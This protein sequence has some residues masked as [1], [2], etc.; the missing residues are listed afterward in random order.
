MPTWQQLRDVKLSEF[1]DAAD[2]WGKVSSRANAAKDRVDNEMRARIHETQKSKTAEGAV[3]DLGRLS[4]NYQYLHTE[5]GL[6]RTALDGLATELAEPQRKLKQALEDAENLKFT[7]ESD[8]AVKY[9]TTVAVTVP[10]APGP[11]V[12]R[13]GAPVPFLAGKGEGGGDPNKAKAEDIAERIAGA[14]RDAAEIDGRY[15]GVLRRLKSPAG[16]DVTN[17]MLVDAAADTKDV[18]KNAKFLPESNIPKGKSPADNK[19]WWDGLS[20]EERDEYATLY[21]AA[22][23]ALDG[24]PATVRDDA[25]R[26]VLAETRAQVQLDRDA[27]GPEPDRMIMTRRGGEPV[28]IENPEWRKWD[29]KRGP[30]DAKLKGMDAIQARFD[31]TG[32]ADRTGEHPLPEAYL[33]GFNADGIG[34]AIVANGNPDTATHTSVYVP[35]TG[36]NLEGINGDI[37]RMETLW[38]ASSAM[39]DGSK[40]STVTWF[41]YDA[42]QSIITDA[43]QSGYANEGGPV[44]NNFLG[45]LRASHE[46]EPGHLTAV[47]HSYGSTVI[48]SAAR[49]G[50]LP[51]DDVFVAG[52]PGEQVGHAS[53]M[54]VKKGHVWAANA[55]SEPFLK[56]IPIPFIGDDKYGGINIPFVSSDPVPEIGGWGHAPKKL[57]I[58]VLPSWIDGDGMSVV[59]PLTP[60]NP[61]FGANI[62]A[63]DGSR[64]HSGYWDEGTQSLLNQARVTVGKYDKVTLEP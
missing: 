52:S 51:V 47:G 4:R 37:K 22:V 43:P 46:G 63:T 48:G 7:V 61:D 24:V 17:E 41:G 1:S 28:M 10:L 26:M 14:V 40:V 11:G 25:N 64:G 29:K 15:A 23:G 62:V 39:A 20:Q 38:R 57:D 32:E 55:D 49:Q 45:G 42:P 59:K 31:R 56:G 35:G 50:T 9:P 60:S 21:P 19:K 18:Q 34:R 44:L 54:D 3:G 36:T 53:E 33:L 16:L 58:D 2:G 13:P 5:C 30:L 6:I 27:L 8:G 12:A